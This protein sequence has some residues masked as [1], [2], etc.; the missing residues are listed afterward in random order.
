[1]IQSVFKNVQF[2]VGDTHTHKVTCC[3]CLSQILECS[4]WICT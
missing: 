1:L 4:G 3:N 2:A